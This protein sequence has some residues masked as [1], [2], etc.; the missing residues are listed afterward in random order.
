MNELLNKPIVLFLFGALLA[1]GG[2]YISTQSTAQV[3]VSSNSVRIA[4]LEEYVSDHK[5]TAVSKDELNRLESLIRDTQRNYVTKDE[6]Q[7]FTG[8]MLRA[9]QELRDEIRDTRRTR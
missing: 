6:F 8:S 2:N 3:T 7:Q 4:A 9:V 5:R 1:V